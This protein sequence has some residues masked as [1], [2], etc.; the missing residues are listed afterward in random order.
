MPFAAVE[1]HGGLARA[2]PM[3]RGSPGSRRICIR[4]VDRRAFPRRVIPPRGASRRAVR[5]VSG[6]RRFRHAVRGASAWTA[7]TIRRRSPG[8]AA[9]PRSGDGI[10]KPFAA[11]RATRSFCWRATIRQRLCARWFWPIFCAHS[12]WGAV[13]ARHG[14]GFA[15]LQRR[16]ARHARLLRYAKNRHG[17]RRQSTRSPVTFGRAGH[18][19]G[20]GVHWL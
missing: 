17:D 3:A 12:L 7:S 20:S 19:R 14:A 9:A 13:A 16:V 18:P 15:W 5:I 1:P 4:A 11:S 8:I 2:G 10:R 6:R